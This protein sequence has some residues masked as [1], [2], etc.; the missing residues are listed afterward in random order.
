MVPKAL[1]TEHK[2]NKWDYIELESF[3]TA[4]ETMKQKEKSTY[5]AGENIYKYST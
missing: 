2:I 3:C 1:A 5:G 4:K